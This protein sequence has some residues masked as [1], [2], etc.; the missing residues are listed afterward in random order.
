[1][2]K[3]SEASVRIKSLLKRKSPFVFSSS[4]K[5]PTDV[6][7]IGVNEDLKG[8]WVF[9]KNLYE[10]GPALSSSKNNALFP[11]EGIEFEKSVQQTLTFEGKVGS[12]RKVQNTLKEPWA[13]FLIGHLV[14]PET[15]SQDLAISPWLNLISKA[16]IPKSKTS[17][18]ASFY[19]NSFPNNSALDAFKKHVIAICSEYEKLSF[20]LP[21]GDSTYLLGDPKSISKA[22]SEYKKNENIKTNPYFLGKTEKNA[23]GALP[24]PNL[25]ETGAC[26]PVQVTEELLYD[27]LRSNSAKIPLRKRPYDDSKWKNKNGEARDWST[28]T[29]NLYKDISNQIPRTPQESGDVDRTRTWL[30]ETFLSEYYDNFLKNADKYQ[31]LPKYLVD[32]LGTHAFYSRP[33][34]DA[35]SDGGKKKTSL[36]GGESIQGIPVGWSDVHLGWSFSKKSGSQ[37]YTC[38]QVQIPT[39]LK[40]LNTAIGTLDYSAVE[41]EIVFGNQVS[42]GQVPKFM[43]DSNYKARPER[44]RLIG[45]G[46]IPQSCYVAALFCFQ[47]LLMLKTETASGFE[48][49]SSLKS[50]KSVET[51]KNPKNLVIDAVSLVGGSLADN[52]GRQAFRLG[53]K[54]NPYK[55]YAYSKDPDSYKSLQ[56][57][58]FTALALNSYSDADLYFYH[59]VFGILNKN[60]PLGLAFEDG[61]SA[62]LSFCTT[63]L[64]DVREMSDLNSLLNHSAFSHSFQEFST[65]VCQDCR[66]KLFLQVDPSVYLSVR[67]NI[68]KPLFLSNRDLPVDIVWGVPKSY[69]ARAYTFNYSDLPL[70]V[71]NYK[72]LLENC[73]LFPSFSTATLLSDNVDLEIDEV[74]LY[75]LL[76]QKYNFQIDLSQKDCFVLFVGNKVKKADFS[77]DFYQHFYAPYLNIEHPERV[78]TSV[79]QTTD[80]CFY[81]VLSSN[82]PFLPCVLSYSDLG[83]TKS[84]LQDLKNENKIF[85]FIFLLLQT[86]LTENLTTGVPETL[87]RYIIDREVFFKNMSLNEA[88]NVFTTHINSIKKPAWKILG[89]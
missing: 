3:Y 47:N 1:M 39:S 14:K 24:L 43:V 2:H 29:S 44:M 8:A 32:I 40:V 6:K 70:G 83:V 79:M 23:S 87:W 76:F 48:S 57:V 73:F 19:R 28:P 36:S 20:F 18:E 45:N 71:V 75:S 11:T 89:K 22:K 37:G 86:I 49:I 13:C 10:N 4:R 77:E 81:Y 46:V 65:H 42:T 21:L 16:N 17:R 33:V 53:E 25:Y 56:D 63:G 84:Y 38:T 55:I 50:T 54:N 72:P 85:S 12:L 31:A 64:L 27:L 60:I 62:S 69:D 26:E 78:P 66:L 58:P 35:L 5:N 74:V 41:S 7:D 30:A 61:A 51:P 34:W 88:S 9:P 15:A 68:L 80:P 67:Q 59:P 82:N 52:I